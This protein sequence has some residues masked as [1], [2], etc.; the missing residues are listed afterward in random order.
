MTRPTPPMERLMTRVD[1]TSGEC[2]LW[3]GYVTPDGYGRFRPQGRKTRVVSTHRWVYEQLVGPIPAGLTIDHLCRVRNCL[4]PAH[5]EPVEHRVNNARGTSPTAI[6]AR[7]T[8]CTHG[9]ELT[10]DNL[11]G[12]PSRRNCKT[13]ASAASRRKEPCPLCG[14]QLTKTGVKRH[15]D[16]AACPTLKAAA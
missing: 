10:P 5:M 7:R 4:N 14:K 3:T 2:W 11:Y 6:N 12:W 9:H 16:S 15:L 8:H 1:K 13:C